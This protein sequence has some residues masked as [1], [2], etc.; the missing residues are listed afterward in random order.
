MAEPDRIVPTLKHD[1]VRLAVLISGG[2]TTMQNLAELIEAGRLNAK[3]S[4]VISSREEAGGLE[5]ASRLKLPSFVVPRP[6]YD[7]AEAFSDDVFGLVRDTGADLVCMAGF[8]SLLT[9]PDDYAHNVINI[10]PALLPAFGGQGMYGRH[11]HKAVL[12]AGCK[13][14]GCTVHF[15]DPEYDRGPIIVQ[16]ACPVEEDDT[17]DT[18]AARVIEQ[19]RIAYPEAVRLLAAG[20]V[21][22]EG[23]RTRIA[24]ADA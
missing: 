2:G 5:R 18:L 23:P 19:E 13:L 9:I 6:G 3:I 8:L 12:A 4:V 14:S 20:R 21:A 24:P 22:I 10:H 15:A 17:P 16:R 11:V 7:T 1:P